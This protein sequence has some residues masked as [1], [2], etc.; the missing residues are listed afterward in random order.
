[1]VMQGC[2]SVPEQQVKQ[3]ETVKTIAEPVVS[4]EEK[5][6][7]TEKA[8]GY[9]CEHN[10]KVIISKLK[11][12]NVCTLTED[13]DVVELSCPF[14]CY[15]LLNMDKGFKGIKD[16]IDAYHKNCGTC[17]STCISAP[18]SK[19]P[20]FSRSESPLSKARPVTYSNVTTATNLKST[21]SENMRMSPLLLRILLLLYEKCSDLPSIEREPGKP[22]NQ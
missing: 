14:D 16:R 15:S 22:L 18:P 5:T 2:A 21:S 6:T 4:M 13:C 9:D 1:M 8:E 12:K 19:I 10:K 3:K 20:S 17:D 7:T 11:K